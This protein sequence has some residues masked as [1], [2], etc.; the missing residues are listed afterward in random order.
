MIQL[1]NEYLVI[2]IS[3][4]HKRKQHHR[5]I[6]LLVA[7]C[8]RTESHASEPVA[9]D[10]TNVQSK[11]TRWPLLRKTNS[12][13]EHPNRSTTNNNTIIRQSTTFRRS[14]LNL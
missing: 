11:S 6:K 9:S 4:C 12:N 2:R 5:K 3:D 13:Q 1:R 10:G 14:K 8:V 7:Y